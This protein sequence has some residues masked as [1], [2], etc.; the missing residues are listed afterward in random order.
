MERVIHK[1]KKL[2]VFEKNFKFSK[3][4]FIFLI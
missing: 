3:T 4:I 1:E 2:D